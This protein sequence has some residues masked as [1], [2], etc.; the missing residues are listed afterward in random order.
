[1][2]MV[3]AFQIS[4]GVRE[5]QE[6]VAQCK[7]KSWHITL[8]LMQRSQDSHCLHSRLFLYL[9]KIIWPVDLDPVYI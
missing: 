6:V 9:C 8:G 1:M 3:L 4:Q 7:G 2:T 5:V